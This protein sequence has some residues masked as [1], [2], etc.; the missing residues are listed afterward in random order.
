MKKDNNHELPVTLSGVAVVPGEIVDMDDAGIPIVKPAEGKVVN[1]KL[2]NV[3][4]QASTDAEILFTLPIDSRVRI[5]FYDNDWAHITT[6]AGKTGFV[7]AK[8]IK[9]IEE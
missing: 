4:V 8:F 3:R 5:D 2:L 9:E 1:C 7:M 6:P